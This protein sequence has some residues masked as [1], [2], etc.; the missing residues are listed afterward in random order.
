MYHMAINNNTRDTISLLLVFQEKKAGTIFAFMVSKV[1]TTA[2]TG[3]IFHQTTPQGLKNN[4][5]KT[6]QKILRSGACWLC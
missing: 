5:E 3:N 6:K 1:C 2:H 4:R